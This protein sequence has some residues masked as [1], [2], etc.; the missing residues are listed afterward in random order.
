LLCKG[1]LRLVVENICFAQQIFLIKNRRKPEQSQDVQRQTKEN[2]LQIN[3]FRE[4][5]KKT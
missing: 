5:Q 3:I 2:L 4:K 1:F